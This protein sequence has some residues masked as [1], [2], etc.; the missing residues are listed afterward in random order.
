MHGIVMY[1][2]KFIFI[3]VPPSPHPLDS[4]G[5]LVN[6]MSSHIYTTYVSGI[7]G[8]VGEQ[9]CWRQ[10]RQHPTENLNIR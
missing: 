6:E 5:H 9:S 10:R 3:Y 2:I 1:V 7:L 8:L 4:S